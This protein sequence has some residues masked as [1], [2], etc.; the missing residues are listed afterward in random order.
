[1]YVRWTIMMVALGTGGFFVWQHPSRG[2]LSGSPTFVV[3]PY[4]NQEGE[5]TV[6]ASEGQRS[7]AWLIVAGG[8]GV[9][10]ISVAAVF[11]RLRLRSQRD[12]EF[13][14]HIP[15]S[16]SLENKQAA[17]NMDEAATPDTVP[18][19]AEE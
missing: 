14:Y 17:E 13:V 19:P 16:V 7:H 8:L 10:A 12:E 4:V 1:M 2:R 3:N 5:L 15:L 11:D 9:I 6:D 18:C